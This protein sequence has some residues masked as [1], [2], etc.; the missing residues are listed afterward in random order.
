[1]TETRR[2]SR[3]RGRPRKRGTTVVTVRLSTEALDRYCRLALRADIH[4]RS[5]IRRIL[6][7]HAP[8]ENFLCQERREQ[9]RKSA[10]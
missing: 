8:S 3:P 9:P 5:V 7:K 2:P 4:V 10:L 6:E 1:M